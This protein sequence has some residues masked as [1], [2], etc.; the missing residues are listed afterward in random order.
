MKKSVSILL[1]LFLVSILIQSC[2]ENTTTPN[3]TNNEIIPLK[4]GNYWTIIRTDYSPEGTINY[5]DTVTTFV[6]RDSIWKDE[7]I[8]WMGTSPTDFSNDSVCF[9]N[10]S[11]GHYY[12]N[13]KFHTMPQLAYKY[14]AKVNDF[15]LRSLDT[16]FVSKK[17]LFYKVPAG[18]FICYQY[19]LETTFYR[20]EPF[21]SEK[22]VKLLHYLAP[23]IGQIAF[24]YYNIYPDG[25]SYLCSKEV[26]L[27]Y[28]IK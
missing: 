11:D 5:I 28:N 26:L 20:L 19:R 25:Q 14:P 24:E 8:Y 10:R 9:L 16:M 4:V 18:N 1:V 21:Y 23:G 17:N 22:V 7:K 2:K 12:M 27:D 15:F 6:V 3:D 13:L